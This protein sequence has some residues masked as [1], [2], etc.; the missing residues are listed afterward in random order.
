MARI[1]LS[2]CSFF[3]NI[4]GGIVSSISSES[5]SST[6]SAFAEDVPAAAAVVAVVAAAA[7]AAAANAAALILAFTNN[8]MGFVMFCRGQGGASDAFRLPWSFPDVSGLP[9]LGLSRE[10]L[11]AAMV[12]LLGEQLLGKQRVR[13]LGAWYRL[14]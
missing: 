3:G 9:W 5:E 2:P 13:R 14:F 4:G 1:I 7:I 11:V 6:V 8:L 12:M 10:R